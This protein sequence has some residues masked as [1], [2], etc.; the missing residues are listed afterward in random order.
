MLS[1]IQKAAGMNILQVLLNNLTLLHE[2]DFRHI[3]EVTTLLL[4][5]TNLI[6]CKKLL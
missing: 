5:C 2:G 1:L 4:V 3:P 6:D